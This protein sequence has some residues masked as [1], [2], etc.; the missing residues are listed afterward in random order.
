MEKTQRERF[1][2][3]VQVLKEDVLI[4]ELETKESEAPKATEDGGEKTTSLE[5][6]TL[7]TTDEILADLIQTL[8]EKN[9]I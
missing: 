5:Q 6:T 9:I 7:R 8:I 1:S 4:E 3:Y 2:E